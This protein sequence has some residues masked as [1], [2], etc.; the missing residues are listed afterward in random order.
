[1]PDLI[2]KQLEQALDELQK[3]TTHYTMAM[4]LIK[5]AQIELKFYRRSRIS[6]MPE[7]LENKEPED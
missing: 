2:K 6:L 7:F 1:M 5:K 3:A 4:A